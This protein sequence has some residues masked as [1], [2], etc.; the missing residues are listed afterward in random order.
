[1]KPGSWKLLRKFPVPDGVGA[2]NPEERDR[3]WK[4]LGCYYF[5]LVA[6]RGGSLSE[7]RTEENY[8]RLFLRFLDPI[9]LHLCSGMPNKLPHLYYKLC[10]KMHYLCYN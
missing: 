7:T 1:M 5:S 4:R 10:F 6:G 9:L 8:E 2:S 3:N